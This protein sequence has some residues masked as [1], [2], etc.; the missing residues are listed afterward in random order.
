[1]INEGP[2]SSGHLT[3][4]ARASTIRRRRISD[5]GS[6]TSLAEPRTSSATGRKYLDAPKLPPVLAPTGKQVCGFACEQASDLRE[7]FTFG[8]DLRGRAFLTVASTG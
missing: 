2:L 1:M 8:C 5:V 7:A 4:R 6:V 3:R